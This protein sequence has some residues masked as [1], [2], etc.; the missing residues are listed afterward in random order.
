MHKRHIH[1][2]FKCSA[3]FIMN[4]GNNM[5][6]TAKEVTVRGSDSFTGAEVILP[7]VT[8]L[9]TVLITNYISH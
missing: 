3:N 7:R 6:P 5:K 8:F 1:I 2:S 4:N 9:H